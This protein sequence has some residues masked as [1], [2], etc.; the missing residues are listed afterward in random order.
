MAEYRFLDEWFVPT[1]PEVV[2]DV[3]GAQTE[4]PEWWGEIGRAHV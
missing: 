3:V 4:Y 2:Y 1:S